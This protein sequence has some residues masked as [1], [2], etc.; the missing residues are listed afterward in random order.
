MRV[1]FIVKDFYIEPL[2]IMYLSA[3]LQRASH[4][5]DIV[6]TSEN[7]FTKIKEFKPDIVA[8]SVI[9]GSHGFFLKLNREIKEGFDILSIMG[10]PHP[11]FFPEVIEEPGLDI[12]CVGEGETAFVE[13]ANKWDEGKDI[14]KI[15]NLLVTRDGV[16]YKND[17]GPLIEDLDSIAFPD[18]EL[19]HKYE[20]I[21]QGPIKH[22]VMSR[23]CPYNC[24]YCYSHSYFELYKE[25]GKRV[26]LRSVDNV[27]AEITECITRYPAKFLYFQDDIFILNK[28]WL[29]EFCSKY[30]KMLDLPFHCHTRADLVDEETVSL[31]KEAGC[32]SVHIAAETADDYVRNEILNR[33][34][35]KEDIRNAVDLFN[36]C[37]IK[38]MLQNMIGLPGGSLKKDIETL[39][40]N[41]EC[42]PEYP[43]VSIFQPYPRTRIAEFCEAQGLYDGNLGAIQERFFDST[44]LKIKNKRE[45]ENLQK[46]FALATHF[47]FIF[48]SGL[49]NFLIKVPRF[50]LVKWL[51]NW[52]HETY[53]RHCDNNLYGIK[54][55]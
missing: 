16:T 44:I 11:T 35:S 36:K 7:V 31:L 46:W 55:H 6:K 22:F 5:V 27:I 45:I 3:A 30:P 34:M 29:R 33:A 9:T 4:F 37:N 51:Y 21:R 13:L 12:V 1:L 19:V 28:K 48:R 23:G 18:R 47:P 49:L 8:Y 52:L 54:L 43:W 41:I 24:T 53:G 42:R 40:L 17:V 15:A 20:K 2:G 38:I 10:G 39:K 26:R 50:N 32:Y 25:K 14:T